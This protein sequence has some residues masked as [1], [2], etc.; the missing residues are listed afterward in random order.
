MASAWSEF[1][2]EIGRR[3]DAGH[4]PLLWW[5]DD[6]AGAPTAEIGRLLELSAVCEVPLALAVVPE[7]AQPALFRMLHARVAV[8]QHGCDH[9]NRAGPGEKKTEFPAAEGDAAALERLVEARRRLE[10]VAGSWTL[11]VLAPPWNRL[12]GTL[13]ARLAEF[14]FRGLSGYGPR[15]VTA[16]VAGLTQVNTHVDIVA[17]HA[18]RGFVGDEQALAML[19]RQL[20]LATEEPIG[21]LTHHAVHEASSWRFLERLFETARRQ[22]ARWAHPAELFLPA[23]P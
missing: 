19:R 20:D 21:I 3:R 22:G 10:A 8:L 15:A 6:D 23:T 16:P 1:E 14:G 11:P 13:A 2:G 7:A 9:V 5:R 18:G 4:A 17:W 12:R